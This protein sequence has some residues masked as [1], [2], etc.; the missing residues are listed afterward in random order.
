MKIVAS[1][2]CDEKQEIQ[3]ISMTLSNNTM[4]LR[5]VE[6]ADHIEET[7]VGHLPQFNYFF[8]Q[9]DKSRDISDND[10]QCVL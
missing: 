5:I 9:V 8:L 6:M 4:K 10:I 2:K 1:Q 3:V 7:A